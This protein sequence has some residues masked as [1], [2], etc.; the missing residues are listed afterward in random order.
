MSDNLRRRLDRLEAQQAQQQGRAVPP[1]FWDVLCGTVKLAY[2]PVS[3]RPAWQRF[4]DEG[5][6]ARREALDR[7]PATAAYRR[8]CARLGLTPRGDLECVDVIEECVRL[9]GI[10]TP[11]WAPRT[12]AKVVQQL[13][14]DRAGKP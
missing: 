3:V 1:L 6:A 2:L 13:Q 12:L 8:E 10:P 11:S 5:S 4:R 14:K 7:H 9:A